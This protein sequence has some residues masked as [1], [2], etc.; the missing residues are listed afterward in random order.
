MKIKLLITISVFTFSAYAQEVNYDEAKVP[1]FDVPD[2]L[3]CNDGTKVSTVKEWENRRRPEIMAFFASQFYGQTPAEKIPV[4]YT[5][6]SENP[7]FMEGK[8]TARQ[9]KFVFTNNGKSLEAILLLLLPNNNKA[10]IPVFVSYNYKGNHSICLDTTILYTPSFSR[11]KTADDPDWKRGNQAT[12]WSIEKIIARGYGVATMF[13]QDIYPDAPNKEDE[14]IVSLFTSYKPDN[15]A[16]DKWQAL[17]AW[18]WGSSRIV[19]YLETVKRVDKEKIII[20]GHSRQG[21][22]ALWAGAQDKRFKIV[23]SN[24]S[25]CGGAALSKRVFG[26]HLARI[27]S[28]FPHWFCPALNFYANNEAALPFDQHEL[29]ALIAPRFAYIASAEDDRWADPKGEFL[30]GV[31]ASPVYN[32]YGLKGLTIN[33]NPKVNQP[34]MNAVGYHIRTGVHDVTDYDWGCYLDFADK[35]LNNK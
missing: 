4:S 8:A 25:G 30:A 7:N 17:G 14:S 10:K 18:A 16:S 33:D 35:L 15:K 20:M 3:T 12:R 9:V 2:P 28:S 34:V 22:S 24:D 6:L 1:A 27:T 5:V 32:L 31:Y 11:L 21:K 19:D 13:Y 29:I 26:E 23:I